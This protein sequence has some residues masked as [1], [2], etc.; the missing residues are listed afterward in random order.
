[1]R[2]LV[3]GGAG[4]I[5]SH[6]TDQ[7]LA[8]GHTVAAFDDL[9]SGSEENLAP[10]VE[11]FRGDIRDSRQVSQ[12]FEELKPQCVSLQAAQVSVAVSVSDPVLDAQANV[13]GLLSVLEAARHAGVERV[14]FASSGGAIYG[15]V[16]EPA[17]EEFDGEPISPYGISKWVGEQYLK[18][19]AN[20][21][22]MQCVA[23]R[24]AN[25]YGPRQNPHGEAGVVAVFS[26]RMLQGEGVRING[27]GKY[28]R[29]YVYVEDVARANMAAFE[30]ELPS[31]CGVF[32]VGTAEGTDV[33][34]LEA[35][36]RKSA[37]AAREVAEETSDIPVPVFG[38]ARVGDIRSSLI[39]PSYTIRAL[40]WNPETDIE[41]GI[42]KTV[43][44][45]AS[46]VVP[47]T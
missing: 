12:V 31:G 40:D 37:I 33:N 4:F 18:F 34:E 36:V 41:L 17:T 23:L 6:V 43:D 35:L 47:V 8:A 9:S 5:G 38:P 15:D 26:T 21:Y 32:N 46:R 20:T 29:D 16:T 25:V 30:A 2:V 1:M 45:F 11:L 13:I 42:Q 10:E 27:D 7:L 24:Y 14:T 39:D 3:T 44:W 28:V 19:Y 22:Q